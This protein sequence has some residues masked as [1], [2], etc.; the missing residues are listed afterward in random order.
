MRRKFL[1]GCD[2]GISVITLQRSKTA[3]CFAAT[4]ALAAETPAP[5]NRGRLQRP[6]DFGCVPKK[7]VGGGAKAFGGA[8]VSE[9]KKS[10][11]I[12]LTGA[13]RKRAHGI[14]NDVLQIGKW[15][16]CRCGNS[17]L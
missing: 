12:S 6:R 13:A 2:G 7:L 5:A 4:E 10:Y 1:G 9:A 16:V 14:Q 11:V 15:G 17:V 8:G 3:A